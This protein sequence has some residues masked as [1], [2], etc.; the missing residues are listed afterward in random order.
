MDQKLKREIIELIDRGQTIP[1]EYQDV[2]F[3]TTKK[4]YELKYAGKEREEVI[5]NSTMAVPFQAVKHFG[6]TKEGEWS[7][8][9]IFGDNLQALKHLLKLKNDGKLK[10]SDGADG[11]KLVYIDP[12]F[13]TKRE[14]SGSNDE[15][16]YQDKLEGANFIEFLRKRIVL[17]RELLA[18][19]GAIYVHLDYRK[20]HYVKVIM[21]ELLKENNFRNEIIVPRTQKNFIEREYVRGLN[22]AYDSILL[23]TKTDSGSLRAPYRDEKKAETWHAF[24][25]PNWSGT[26]PNLI[27]ELFGCRPPNGRCWAWVKEKADEAI[28]N[29]TLRPN[30]NSGRPEYLIPAREKALCTNL[31]TDL[32]AYS[33]KTGYPTEK[34]VKMLLR[35]IDMSSHKGDIVLDCFSGSGSTLVAAEQTNRKWIGI[36]CGKLALYTMQRRLLN[37]KDEISEKGKPYCSKP[38]TLYHAGLYYDGKTLQQ[39]KGDEYKDFVLELFGCQN[40]EHKLNGIQMHGTLNN[41]SV[42]IFDK[43]NYLT[44]EFIDDLHKHIGS[45]I[46]DQLYIIAPIGVVGFAEDYVKREN[47]KYTVLRIPNSIIEH[48]KDK[49]FTKLKQPRSA[50]DINQTIDAV[51]F[52]FI[53][54]PMVKAKYYSEKP[55]G[56]LIDKEY[57][58]EIQDFEPIQLGTN[59]VKFEDPK[60]ES[61]A[62]VM[63][64]FDYNG[65]IFNLSKYFFGD[66]IAKNKF[67]AT[68]SEDI[69]KQVMV[70]YLDIFGNEKKE[71]IAK[72]DFERK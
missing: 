2:L 69:G 30:P 3:P 24:D 38:F 22:I 63:V 6:Q 46:K 35:I 33:F 60:T 62:M 50:D 54:P 70:I 42:M 10:N 40:R 25:A 16:A 34:N 5:L 45:S 65:E 58:I 47:I 27:Y 19:D 13:A 61:L 64:D 48:I 32:I 71:I 20:M 37:I 12:P 57:V 55:K 43:E 56:K 51:G 26:R 28:L 21:D 44:H 59:I 52:D 36:D 53:Y 15:K 11:V 8:M 4:E 9:L 67:K 68:W 23:Y 14:F 29:G 66:E 72:S 1:E 49:N 41:N 18:E 39:M 17:L 7:N 31:W